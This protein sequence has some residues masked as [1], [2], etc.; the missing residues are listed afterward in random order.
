MNR[1]T[2]PDETNFIVDQEEVDRGAV[3]SIGNQNELSDQTILTLNERQYANQEPGPQ[4]GSQGHTP[5]TDGQA[6][7]PDTPIANNRN[8]KSAART[9]VEHDRKGNPKLV[10]RQGE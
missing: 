6:N 4:A 2:L 3:S 9:S 7:T 1:A 10:R 5:G 8:K